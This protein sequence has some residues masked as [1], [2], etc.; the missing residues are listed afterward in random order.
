MKRREVSS[1]MIIFVVIAVLLILFGLFCGFR[2][3]SHIEYLALN[4]S[5]HDAL[6]ESVRASALFAVFLG[7]MVVAGIGILLILLLHM[8]RKSSRMRKETDIL[9]HKI[10]AIEELN[11]QTQILAHHQRLEMLGTLT[12][13]IAH[14]FNNLLTPIMGYSLMAL[15]KLPPDETELY[16]DILEVYN[17]S[18][19]A[20]TL[21]SRLSDLSR[22]NSDNT[23]HPASADDLIQKALVVAMPA[24]PDTVEI[25]LDL[26]C[27]EQRIRANETQISQLILNLI[28]NAFQAMADGGT[29]TIATSYDEKWVNILVSDTGCGIPKEHLQRIYDPFFTTKESGKGTGLGLA[30]AAQVVEDH[31]GTINV[32]SEQGKG[33][34]FLVSIPRSL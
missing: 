32:R 22:K 27:Q 25:K 30:I 11:H 3:L 34:S 28:I 9:R 15:E 23:F 21:I 26:N 2:M 14:E 13:S 20:K 6:L 1:T 16:D 24:K 31:K 4:H 12:S 19:T 29:L 17:A 8:I 10:E 18:R 33:T 5:S 7:G